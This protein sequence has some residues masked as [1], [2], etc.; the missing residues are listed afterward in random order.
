MNPRLIGLIAI[1]FV[2]PNVCFGLDY[3]K[4]T[5]TTEGWLLSD[6]SQ[7]TDIKSKDNS[8]T[9]SF[10][11]II[12]Y[13]KP[14]SIKQLNV[15]S[16]E[17]AGIGTCFGERFY[18]TTARR[19]WNRYGEHVEPMEYERFLQPGTP[20]S[21]APLKPNSIDAIA[22]DFACS[23]RFGKKYKAVNY[24][25]PPSNVK[26]LLCTLEAGVGQDT[27]AFDDVTSRVWFNGKFVPSPSVTSTDINFQLLNTLFYRIN[28]LSGV[29][30]FSDDKATIRGRCEERSTRKF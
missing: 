8:G 10:Q 20:F 19:Y 27:L 14:R 11:Y 9:I 23:E 29:I 18:V 2:A 15:V 3:V 12:Q 1:F 25:S 17:F 4:N 13:T 26:Q 30:E 7:I 22:L 16:T 21:L 28:R 24:A 5:Y 6:R